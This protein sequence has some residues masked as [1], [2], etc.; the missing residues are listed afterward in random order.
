MEHRI[1]A[2]EW[3]LEIGVDRALCDKPQDQGA[4]LRQ[5]ASLPSLGQERDPT[6]RRQNIPPLKSAPKSTA[7]VSEQAPQQ[8]PQQGAV[9]LRAQAKMLAARA[10]TVEELGN[11]V[12]QFEGCALKET[13]ANTV[14]ADGNAAAGL[15]IIGEAPGAEED[16]IGKPFV[17]KSGKLLNTMLYW[18]GI[19]DRSQYMISNMVFWRPPGNRVPTPTETSLCL[20]FVHRLVALTR[21]KCLLILGGHAGAGLLQIPEFRITKE[22]G[23]WRNFTPEGTELSIPA[24]ASFHP[25][26]LLRAPLRKREAW[27]DLRSIQEFLSK[28]GSDGLA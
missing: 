7:S 2:L 11:F 25:S 24:L 21:P 27:Q 3:L 16:R 22:R 23:K 1:I 15:L 4:P 12:M 18:I 9:A 19:R 17:G 26:F 14:F 13:A 5:A 20:P 6:L 28:T 10:N 8:S